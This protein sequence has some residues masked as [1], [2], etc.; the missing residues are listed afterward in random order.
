[1]LQQIILSMKPKQ[2][3]AWHEKAYATVKNKLSLPLK[4]EL[5]YSF[6]IQTKLFENQCM[7]EGVQPIH[8]EN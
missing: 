5:S 7:K 4:L 8:S 6:P 3:Q 1:M 2:Y